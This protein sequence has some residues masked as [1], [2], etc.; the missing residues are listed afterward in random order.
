MVEGDLLNYNIVLLLYYTFIIFAIMESKK[1]KNN[2][3]TVMVQFT[4]SDYE[5]IKELA[6]ANNRSLKNYIETLVMKEKG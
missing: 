2:K 6:L 3:V 5:R 4:I 1:Y